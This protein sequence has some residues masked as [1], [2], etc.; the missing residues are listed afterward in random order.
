MFNCLLVKL[1]KIHPHSSLAFS[2]LEL[3]GS[4][5]KEWL[6]HMVIGHED[7]ADLTTGVDLKGPEVPHQ[8]HLCILQLTY[9]LD[10]E[11]RELMEGLVLVKDTKAF[12]VVADHIGIRFHRIASRSHV[13]I[14]LNENVNI[15][16]N[17]KPF[18]L[19]PKAKAKVG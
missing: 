19:A 16:Q 11:V 8:L 3:D 1:P 14:E 2:Q 5:N 12:P 4:K 10:V 18:I 13:E 17:L 6:L 7:I 15:D 9:E